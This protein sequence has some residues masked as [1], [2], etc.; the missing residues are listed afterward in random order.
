MQTNIVF[1]DVPISTIAAVEIIN[2]AHDARV[3]VRKRAKPNAASTA[4]AITY[5]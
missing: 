3:T 5:S 2:P 1:R 4:R